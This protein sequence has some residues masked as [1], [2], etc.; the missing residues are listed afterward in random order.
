MVIKKVR[1][2]RLKPG[3]FIH[4]F[5]QGW[6]EIPFMRRSLMLTDDKMITKILEHGI[7][8][9]YIDTS[10]GD[11]ISDAPTAE[12]AKAMTEKAVLD[13]SGTEPA[14]VEESSFV[15]EIKRAGGIRK[16]AQTVITN[17]MESI[18]NGKQIDH[19]VVDKVVDDL[20]DSIFNNSS[21]LLCLNQIR[22][23]DAYTFQH[24]VSV[25]TLMTTFCKAM[26]FKKD[27]TKQ[28]AV[29][30]LLHD[31]GKMFIPKEILN[32]PSKL[33]PSEFDVMKSH[34][35]LARNAFK[36]YDGISSSAENVI[37]QHHEKFD[38]SGYPHKL[39]GAEISNIGLM[40][41]IVDV[42]DALTANR[43]YHDGMSPT[44]ALQKI[45]E[46]S[47]YHF[48]RDFVEHFIRTLGVYPTGTIVT[49]S[50]GFVAVVVETST[51]GST[52]PKVRVVFNS[53]SK[54][55]VSPHI[56]VDLSDDNNIPIYGVIKNSELPG[57]WNIDAIGLLTKNIPVAV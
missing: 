19:R 44:E 53:K 4:D 40:G 56:D 10:K 6:L 43:C 24:S 26:K 45:Y 49:L 14:K 17:T 46:W 12:E 50:S 8:E 57:T 25:C 28:V 51:K 1:V 42:Y 5:D 22:D 2:E 54:T 39:K 34:V 11:D 38:G 3:I 18:R 7:H 35:L 9:V 32:K 21:A 47:T 15:Q 48:K 55:P 29:G 20:V 41:A 52:R 33:T 27:L 36:N 31:L 13:I 23:R 16:E 30:A 37:M